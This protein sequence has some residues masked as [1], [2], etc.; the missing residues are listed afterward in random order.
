MA[1]ATEQKT[2]VPDSAPAPSALLSVAAPCRGDGSSAPYP[3]QPQAPPAP[4]PSAQRHPPRDVPPRFRQQEHKQLLKRGQPL[5]PGL[6][7]L[8]PQ[9]PAASESP[10]AASLSSATTTE[11]SAAEEQASSSS[12]SPASS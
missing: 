2:K 4:P 11:A 1:L 5:P 12:S 9:N 7:T 6:L 3:G 10:L 8:P